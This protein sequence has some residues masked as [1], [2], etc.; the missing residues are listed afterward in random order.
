M[1]QIVKTPVKHDF[2]SRLG[3]SQVNSGVSNG[4]T[5][6]E[7]SGKIISSHSPVDGEPIAS[8][9]VATPLEYE[10]IIQKATSAF[11]QWKMV[12]A[13]KRGEIVRQIGL[14]LR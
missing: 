3:I 11:N 12:P 4:I 10:E 1:N 5:P 2:L 14:R 6:I 8:V 13:P 7:S 9:K